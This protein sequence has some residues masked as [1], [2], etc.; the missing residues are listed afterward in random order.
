MTR[1]TQTS[2]LGSTTSSALLSSHLLHY[3]Y[4]DELFNKHDHCTTETAPGAWTKGQPPGDSLTAWLLGRIAAA[5]AWYLER[6]TDVTDPLL[7]SR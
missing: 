4:G 2:Y 6:G 5:R 3:S 7:Y 1:L